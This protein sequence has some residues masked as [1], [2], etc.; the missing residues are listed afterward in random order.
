MRIMVTGH[1]GYI[2]KIL[3]SVLKKFAEVEGFSM[4]FQDERE[5]IKQADRA[6]R[7]PFDIIVH[8]ATERLQRHE[9]NRPDAEQIFASNYH[10]TKLLA[11]IARRDRSKMIFT[12]TCSSIQP[13]S[14]YTW[15]KRCSADLIMAMLDDY[16]ILNGDITYVRLK[17]Q[18]VYVSVLMDVFTRVIRG[19]QMSR[20]LTQPLTLRP[21][22]Q[23]L[24]QKFTIVTKGFNIFR[25]L[26]F[27][28]SSVMGLRFP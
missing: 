17:G 19:W 4:S 14:F 28:R 18:F 16:C 8:A 1:T 26:I 6:F 10:C 5:W 24:F 27:P 22:Q 20:H 23:A 21:L 11:N 13:F 2:G 12:S 9:Q 3:V 15:A 25:Q 7:Y